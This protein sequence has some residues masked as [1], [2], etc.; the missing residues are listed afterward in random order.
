MKKEEKK[1]VFVLAVFFISAVAILLIR[2]NYN[3]DDET[4]VVYYTNTA[5]LS[6]D[7]KSYTDTEVS[8]VSVIFPV[9]INNVTKEQLMYIDGVGEKTAT[10]IISYRIENGGFVLMEQLLEIDGIG[11]K[12]YEKLLN[13]LYVSIDSTVT[14]QSIT[15][16]T[17][18]PETTAFPTQTTVPLTSETTTVTVTTTLSTT[19]AISYPIDINFATKEELMT[20]KGIGESKAE[21]IIRYR[22]EVSYFYSIYEITNVSGIGDATF[23]NIRNY[24]YVD[25]WLLPQRIT[26]SEMTTTKPPQTSVTTTI[27]TTATTPYYVNINT[28]SKEELMN[29]LLLTE[30]EADAVIFHRSQPGCLFVDSLEL[31]MFISDSKYNKICDRVILQG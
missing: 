14:S 17:V 21:S 10:S 12:T 5:V 30:D 2:N 19:S 26:T 29:Y 6:Q 15:Q 16:S 20:L 24:I 27:T 13:Y 9:D 18:K 31:L 11:Q 22:E 7:E 1:L 23:E 4:A 28:A 25:T 3:T 8:S